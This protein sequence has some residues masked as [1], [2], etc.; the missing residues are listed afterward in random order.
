MAG[1]EEAFEEA[2]RLEV[3]DL[4]KV[5]GGC[6]SRVS[7]QTEVFKEQYCNDSSLVQAAEAAKI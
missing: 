1:L 2:S 6:H 3:T 4:H 7:C 5:G